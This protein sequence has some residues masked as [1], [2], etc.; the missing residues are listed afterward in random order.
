MKDEKML[1]DIHTHCF[2][3]KIA[4]RA[5]EKLAYASGGLMPYYDGTFS[6]LCRAM[7]DEGAV[8]FAVQNIATNA[9]QMKNV[10]DFA[11]MQKRDGV[12]PF[13]SVYPDAPDVLDEVRR[14]KALG[15]RGIKLHPD[16]QNFFVD[17]EKMI[18]IYKEI[19]AQGL[20]L[21]FHAG[22]DYGFRAPFGCTPDRLQKALKYL[23]CPV[24]AA[25]WGGLGEGE[26][27]IR[28]L[29]GLPLYFDTS[30]G[31]GT[32]PRSTA[33][34]IVEAHGTSKLLF[35]SD[36]PWHR[37]SDEVRLLSTLELSADETED[38]CINNAAALLGFDKNALAAVGGF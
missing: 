13:G 5:I 19:S 15:L 17:D 23:D 10:N 11:A 33:L 16:Y 35:G 29:C 8:G 36:S 27:V 21:L 30:F 31:C 18:P 26:E 3:D 34:R 32:M 12:F 24:I 28:R 37:P 22:Q 14:I 38:I 9:G 1:F 4:A 2:P 20:C 25:H 6:G 7:K